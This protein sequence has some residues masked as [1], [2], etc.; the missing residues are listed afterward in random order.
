MNDKE[1]TA[2]VNDPFWETAR[3]VWSTCGTE[4]PESLAEEN[5]YYLIDLKL[6]AGSYKSA[7]EITDVDKTR[8]WTPHQVAGHSLWNS[9]VP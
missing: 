7:K 1:N 8:E 5:A 6:T 2:P 3:I 4:L 9:F